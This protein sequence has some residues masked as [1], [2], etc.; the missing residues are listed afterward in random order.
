MEP[1]RIIM[2]SDLCPGDILMLTAA[3]R[4]LHLAHPGRFITDVRTPVSVRRDHNPN[5]TTLDTMADPAV[6]G[7]SDALSTGSQEECSGRI[8][9]YTLTCNTWKKSLAFESQSG[10]FEETFI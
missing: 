2:T 5:L 9:S 4:E 8:I 3:V 6:T 10:C 1:H 7:D